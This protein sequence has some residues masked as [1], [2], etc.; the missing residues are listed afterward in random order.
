MGLSRK[1]NNRPRPSMNVTPLVD[2]VLVLLIIFMVVLPAMEEGLSIDVPSIA[3]R[4]EDHDSD[5]EPFLISITRDGSFYFDTTAIRSAEF[6][7]FLRQQHTAQPRRKVV[8]RVDGA[9]QYVRVR[10]M[11]H[12]CREIGFPGVSLRVNA[13]PAEGAQASAGGAPSGTLVARQDH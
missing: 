1:G 9:V 6:E 11:M 12:L 3:N 7:G 2:V 10:E 5:M 13:R 4:D 8:L